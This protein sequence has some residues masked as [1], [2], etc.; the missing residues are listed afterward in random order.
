MQRAMCCCE[1]PG[2]VILCINDP[3]VGRGTQQADELQTGRLRHIGALSRTCSR[4]GGDAR[5][6][7]GGQGH[8]PQ[9]APDS[10]KES[11]HGVA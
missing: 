3:F 7:R 4:L 8:S 5:N 11:W 10:V 9:T 1:G 6:V 2:L